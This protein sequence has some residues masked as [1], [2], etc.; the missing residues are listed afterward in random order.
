LHDAH[1]SCALS[2]STRSL[3]AIRHGRGRGHYRGEQVGQGGEERE[4]THVA[5]PT[6][7][8]VAR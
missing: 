1:T 2:S 4:C 7:P 5:A 8:L 3:I 6:T